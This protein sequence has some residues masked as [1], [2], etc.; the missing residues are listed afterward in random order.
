MNMQM[1]TGISMVQEPPSLS[2]EY[3][4]GVQSIL[5]TLMSEC[6]TFAEM[7]ARSAG[8]DNISSTDLLYALQYQTH[9][10]LNTENLEQKIDDVRQMDSDTESSE[11][12]DD[13]DDEDFTRSFS[14]DKTIVQM[15]L[16]HDQWGSWEPQ[17][18]MAR[19]LK[20]AIDSKF[21]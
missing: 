8:R 11:I 19:L 16:Y 2:E 14:K 15:N 18:P 5:L 1:R 10:F 12:D 7:Y 3:L 6:F 21:K 13:S 9:E 4:H 20:D 17:D